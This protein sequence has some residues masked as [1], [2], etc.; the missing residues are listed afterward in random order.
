ML[1]GRRQRDVVVRIKN[2]NTEDPGSNPQFRLIWTRAQTKMDLSTVMPRANSPFVNN[3]LFASY[4]LG[5]LTGREGDSNITL[6]NPFRGVVIK[7]SFH[8][9]GVIREQENMFQ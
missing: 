7:Y 1:K 5:F 4:Q 8:L 9:N 2:L 6:K 3:Q